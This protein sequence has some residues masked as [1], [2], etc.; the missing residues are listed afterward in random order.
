MMRLSGYSHP[1]D[2]LWISEANLPSALGEGKADLHIYG[3][4]P[5]EVEKDEEGWKPTGKTMETLRESFNRLVWHNGLRVR[6]AI[7]REMK[8][9]GISLLFCWLPIRHRLEPEI[10]KRGYLFI[11]AF[12]LI[13][14]V[15]ALAE[16]ALCLYAG[17]GLRRKLEDF[18]I[19]TIRI[20]AR[21]PRPPMSR[22]DTSEH[23]V[24]RFWVAFLAVCLTISCVIPVSSSW[25]VARPLVGKAY[26]TSG[27]TLIRPFTTWYPVPK[28]CEATAYI[29]I[30]LLAEGQEIVVLELRVQWEVV[31][32]L[33]YEPQAWLRTLDRAVGAYIQGVV[34]YVHG[35]LAPL[36]PSEEIRAGRVEVL[37]RRDI[38]YIIDEIK[39]MEHSVPIEIL[40]YEIR[41][42]T[43]GEYSNYWQAIRQ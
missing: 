7:V 38:K 31:D 12:V 5:V 18:R 28:H 20:F 23:P 17:K 32:P 13:M 25:I 15:G 3:D 4:H 26:I 30:R 34:E 8:W 37:M 11:T 10:H 2:G 27:P 39:G 19:E 42:I 22:T 36:I 40:R 16:I 1:H 35:L 24:L 9:L 33:V 41:T 6:K 29:P 14:A 43:I 21:R